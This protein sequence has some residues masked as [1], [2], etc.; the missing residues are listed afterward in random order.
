[1]GSFPTHHR[2]TLG[3]WRSLAIDTV[4]ETCA[5]SGLE[6]VRTLHRF[7]QD[8]WIGVRKKS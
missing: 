1:M 2:H 4:S 3:V 7:T 5:N 8:T 6:V